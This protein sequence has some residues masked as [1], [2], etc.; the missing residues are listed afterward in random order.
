MKDQIK[1][2]NT[3][4]YKVSQVCTKMY[5]VRPSNKKRY[6]HTKNVGLIATFC[7]GKMG[8]VAILRHFLVLKKEKKKKINFEWRFFGKN[9]F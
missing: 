4:S 5:Q 1:P 8:I 3:I 2:L 9:D 6:K 7:A